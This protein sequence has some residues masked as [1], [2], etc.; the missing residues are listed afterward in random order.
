[1][2]GLFQSDGKTSMG[3][4]LSFCA[5]MTGLVICIGIVIHHISTGLAID[6]TVRDLVLGLVGTG[7]VGKGIQSFGEKKK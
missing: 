4:F 2:S 1:M 7:I 3:R 6:V 5:T